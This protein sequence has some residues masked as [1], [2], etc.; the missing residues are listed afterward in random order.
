MQTQSRTI[1]PRIGITVSQ[2]KDAALGRIYNGVSLTY[3][4]A[5]RASGGLPV[6]LPILL[7]TEAEQLQ[8]LDGLLFS[9]GVDVD[10]ER[11]GGEH[12]R[13]LG[14]VDAGRDEFELT[15]YTHARAANKPVLGVCR[16][17]QLINVA[18][19]GTL[20]QHIPGVEGLWAD[21]AQTA[22]PPARGHNV[23]VVADTQLGAAYPNGILKVNSYHHQGLRD[24][25][26]GLV[27]NAY[28]PDG[29]IEGFE[30]HHLVAVQWHPELL[31]EQHPEH[32]HAFQLLVNMCHETAKV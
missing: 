22:A 19:G 7:G 2:S 27:A 13:G 18:E 4:R 11:W 21:H 5:I 31:F 9:G 10:P 6:L 32:L 12:E 3:A 25:A 15:L 20:H 28:A 30:A 24:L 16:G 26:P 17:I 14:E 8:H 1:A 29:L 23:R